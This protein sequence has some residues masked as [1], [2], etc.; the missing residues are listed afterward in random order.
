MLS[1]RSLLVA[2]QKALSAVLKATESKEELLDEPQFCHYSNISYCPLSQQGKP[3]DA[4]RLSFFSCIS[5]KTAVR[6]VRLQPA[7]APC[8][9]PDKSS[10]QR[11][12]RLGGHTRLREI[13]ASGREEKRLKTT[14]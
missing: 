6:L 10:D 7:V 9:T 13:T 3:V 5:I 11:H 2:I 12:R 1:V 4:F 14:F 8:A